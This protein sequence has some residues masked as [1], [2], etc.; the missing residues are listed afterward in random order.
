MKT[1]RTSIN[2]LHIYIF[3]V[4]LTSLTMKLQQEQI[5]VGI[6]LGSTS[7]TAI[8]HGFPFQIWYVTK[9]VTLCM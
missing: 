8:V 2:D 7:T 3:S 4:N 9:H 5:Y 1:L 6:F